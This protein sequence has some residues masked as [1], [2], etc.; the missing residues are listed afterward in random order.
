[1]RTAVRL[2]V[3]PLLAV[4]SLPVCGMGSDS[5][6][7]SPLTVAESSGYKATSTSR[8]VVRF[9]QQVAQQ[10]EHV[11]RMNFGRS[12]EGRPLVAAVAAN[13]P[14]T[15]PADLTDDPRAVV[16]CLG[17]I[18]SGE[19]AG[20]EAL[21]ML[22]REVAHNADHPLLK[23]L[24]LIFVPNYSPDAND[25]Q[26]KDHRPGQL[27]PEQGMGLRETAQGYDLNRDFVK[28][29]AVEGRA[30]VRL[31]NK[32]D[33][34]L[35]I[36]THTTNGSRHQYHLTYDVPHNPAGPQAIRDFLRQQMMPAVTRQL[37]QQKIPTFF[38][39][40]YDRQQTQW[41]TYGDLP[42][43]GIEYMGLRGRMAILSE[44]HKYVPYQQRI[45][46]SREFVRQCLQFLSDHRDEAVALLTAERAKIVASGERPAA[47]DR[48]SIQ[49]EVAPFDG[50]VTIKGLKISQDEDGNTVEQPQD[51]EVEH[52]ARFVPTLEVQRPFAYLLPAAESRVADR[53]LMHGVA[54]YQ[55]TSDV[56]LP[57]QSYQVQ[58]VERASRAYQGH[59][60]VQ[61][62][63]TRTESKRM[64]RSGTYVIPAGQ[65]LGSLV[66]YLLEPQSNDGLATWNFFDP[67]LA[68]E[69]EFPVLRMAAPAP[70]KMRRVRQVQP[71]MLLNLNQIYGPEG[72]VSFSG[73]SGSA[74]WLPNSQHYMRRVG[75]RSYAVDAETGAIRRAADGSEGLADALEKLPEIDAQT[76]RRLAGAVSSRSRDGKSVL[77]DWSHDLFFWREGMEQARR[78]TH[79]KAV[80]QHAMFSPDGMMVAFVRNYNLFVV[81]TDGGP[82]RAVTTEGDAKL[83]HG[84]LDWVYQEEL[85]GRG[86]Y[87]SL[88]HI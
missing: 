39:G 59:Q 4:V 38:Y 48:V 3:I 63:A 57:V 11:H 58:K 51:Y 27:G 45:I 18:H 23:N 56:E 12:V 73:S 41:R 55:L 76:A 49:S 13:P 15:S 71:A 72:Q 67:E 75:E 54:L 82:E 29:D 70:L 79:S 87:L 78:L 61:V 60:L 37:E 47:G 83:L 34:H 17:N 62:E 7:S 77:I 14:V 21:L 33:P 68:A 74:R 86:Q 20:K 43:Y 6:P 88:I 1:V 9:V 40:N 35:L 50:K 10:S 64:I 53:L 28:L 19:C 84:V 5:Q 16:L 2:L 31:I 32:W 46:A 81:G 52:W 80:E 8:Q 24:V 36:D 42:R 22:L 44:A 26:G 69:R 25:R 65:P 30:L 85:Y 66:V